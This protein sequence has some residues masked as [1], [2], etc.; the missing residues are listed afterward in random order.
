MNLTPKHQA[1][2][3]LVSNTAITE[4]Y[5]LLQFLVP[6]GVNEIPRPGQFVQIRAKDNAKVLWRR[7]F[8]VHDYNDDLHLIEILVKIIGEG[9]RSIASYKPGDEVDTLFYLG[10]WF[11]PPQE[12]DRVLFVAGGVGIA[13]LHFAI[14]SW[15]S[16]QVSLSLL[17][18]VKTKRE[19]LRIDEIK[20]QLS[21]IEIMTD[22][23]SFGKK[24][25]LIEHPWLNSN[26]IEFNKIYACGPEPVLK[27]LV[28]RFK[29]IREIKVQVSLEHTMACGFGVCLGCIV[30]TTYGNLRTCIEGPVF[31]IHDLSY[32]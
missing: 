6:D 14:K 11:D 23:G 4:Q 17:Y 1:S 15:S 16:P 10:N 26:K 18:G 7:P 21:Q 32:D 24:G 2:L 19:I 31:N 9:T 12:G 25:L 27:W 29:T 30:K 3:I 22:D 13:P 5:H 20:N 28:K 8:S